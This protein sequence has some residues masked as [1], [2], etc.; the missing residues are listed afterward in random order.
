MISPATLGLPTYTDVPI[1]LVYVT[2]ARTDHECSLCGFVI[3]KGDHHWSWKVAPSMWDGDS[4][5]VGHVHAICDAV[6]RCSE[7]F[8]PGEALPDPSD[9]RSE[10]LGEVVSA[11]SSIVAFR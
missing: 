2:R 8:D 3:P 11:T 7:W 1:G 4:W 10:I 5:F 9:F 6:Y